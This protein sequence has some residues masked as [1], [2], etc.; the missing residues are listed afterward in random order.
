MITYHKRLRRKC[1][2]SPSFSFS[3][4]ATDY[5]CKL[6]LHGNLRRA[7][8]YARVFSWIRIILV[9]IIQYYIVFIDAFSAHVSDI[10]MEMWL[11]LSYEIA[12]M[13][14]QFWIPKIRKHSWVYESVQSTTC[15]DNLF[16]QRQLL[17][18]WQKNFRYNNFFGTNHDNITVICFI[19]SWR[20]LLDI[21]CAV[22]YRFSVYYWFPV[23]DCVA[24]IHNDGI[25]SIQFFLIV[26]LDVCMWWVLGSI[27]F[28]FK[29]QKPHLCCMLPRDL[30]RL[31]TSTG[32]NEMTHHQKNIVF[33]N[34]R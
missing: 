19:M 29:Y 5:L 20:I 23:Y 12:Y 6:E 10:N 3:D 27:F 26:H 8:Q 28:F 15:C 18:N 4:Y 32:W 1:Q 13:Q 22:Q 9:Y 24:G 16:S 30:F 21:F 25:R 14:S 33:I 7:E 34:Y 11:L 17:I 31:L 2:R